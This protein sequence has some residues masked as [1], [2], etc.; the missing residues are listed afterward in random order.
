MDDPRR[1][2]V[3][4]GCQVAACRLG[5]DQDVRT[6]FAIPAEAGAAPEHLELVGVEQ[7]SALNKAKI[8][9]VF[10]AQVSFLAVSTRHIATY[11]VMPRPGLKRAAPL[12]ARFPRGFGIEADF[13]FY[14]RYLIA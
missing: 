14:Y 13:S 1:V 11:D 4:I 6:A 2:G 12:A 7:P 3:D 8:R 9:I 10:G 5:S